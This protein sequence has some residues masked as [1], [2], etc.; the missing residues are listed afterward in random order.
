MRQEKD[1]IRAVWCHVGI[2]VPDDEIDDDR[3]STTAAAIGAGQRRPSW[4]WFNRNTCEDMRHP[5]TCAGEYPFSSCVILYWYIPSIVGRMGKIKGMGWSVGGRGGA[6][7]WVD[8]P[9]YCVLPLE[10]VMVDRATLWASTEASGRWFNLWRIRDIHKTASIIW[11]QAHWCMGDTLAPCLTT[12]QANSAVSAQQSITR[13][14]W[15]RRCNTRNHHYW[16]GW[17]Q[18]RNVVQI[19]LD[20][21]CNIDV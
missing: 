8:A 12:S 19:R 4:I 2:A 6:S 21:T 14:P 17:W 1:E 5:V 9:N 11:A 10:R 15:C 20:C 16:L 7:V 3:A 13:G 18:N